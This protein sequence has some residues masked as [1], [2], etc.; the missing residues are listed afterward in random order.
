MYTIVS[1]LLVFWLVGFFAHFGGDLIHG[2]LLI[3]G[4]LFFLELFSGRRAV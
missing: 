3:A 4:V 2:L 1:L